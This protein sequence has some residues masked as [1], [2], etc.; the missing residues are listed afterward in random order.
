MLRVFLGACLLVVAAHG[1]EHVGCCSHEDRREIQYLWESVWSASFTERKVMIAKAVFDELFER[2]PEAKALFSRVK[3]DE[4]DSPEFRAHLLRID[5]GIDIMVNLMDDAPVLYEE[6][7]HLAAQHAARE[8]M[9]AIYMTGI[10]DAFDH[11]LPQIAPCF[12][13]D[14]WHRCFSKITHMIAHELPH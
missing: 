11:V 3:A 1:E 9:K 4:P 13:L 14:A 2:Y 5:N 7:K 12:N 8:G 10:M 6:I